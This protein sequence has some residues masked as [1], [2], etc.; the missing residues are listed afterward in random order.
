LSSVLG[1][2]LGTVSGYF[3]GIAD[4][5]I[6]RVIEILGSIPT[7]PLWLALA[8]ILPPTWPST[9]IYWGIVTILALIGWTDLGRQIRGKALSVRERDFVMAARAGGAGHGHIMFQHVIPSVMSHIIVVVTLAL[10]FMI[11]G[12]SSLS[13]LGLGIKP[14]LA[15]WGLLLQDAQSLHVIRLAPWIM[16]PG[17]FI[18]VT[19][20]C[21]NFFGDGLRDAVDPYS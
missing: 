5:L 18:V 9:R 16:L 21:F 10:P 2:V 14:P 11:L 8:A 20:L 15:S 12:E 7:L 4:V 1:A 13:F 6:Q 19:V 3:G 17:V